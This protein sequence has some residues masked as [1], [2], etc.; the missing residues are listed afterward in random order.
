MGARGMLVVYLLHG[1]GAKDHQAA[2]KTANKEGLRS[3][4]RLA[5][6]QSIY[7]LYIG[8]LPELSP[9]NLKPRGLAAGAAAIL[10]A[11]ARL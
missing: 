3:T 1:Q 6:N 5:T 4:Q 7:V 11:A 8:L 9:K 2:E 10:I